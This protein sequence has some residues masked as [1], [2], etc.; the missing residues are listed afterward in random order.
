MCDFEVKAS[1]M[2]GTLHAFPTRNVINARSPPRVCE[3]QHSEAH[4]CSSF[5][6]IQSITTVKEKKKA[7]EKEV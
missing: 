6:F 7:K 4:R 2:N 3:T 1:C 5:G